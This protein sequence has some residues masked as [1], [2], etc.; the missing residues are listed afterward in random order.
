[1]GPK[2]ADLKHDLEQ[3]SSNEDDAKDFLERLDA[4]RDT[5]PPREK[6]ILA[7]IVVEA[8]GDEPAPEGGQAPE[9]EPTQEEIDSFIEK[10]NRFHD[11]LPGDQHLYV[12]QMLG[13]TAL[14]DKAEVEGYSLDLVWFGTIQNKQRHIYRAACFNR[15]GPQ[16]VR[17]WFRPGAGHRRFACYDVY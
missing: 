7:E 2:T 8:L 13:A 14:K 4:F 15:P 9:G 16:Y 11:E 17:E 10:L 5:L 12:D 1:M 6:A 3:M